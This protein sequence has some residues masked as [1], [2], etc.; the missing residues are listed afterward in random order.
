MQ[1]PG[2]GDVKLG[3]ECRPQIFL[4]RQGTIILEGFLSFRRLNTDPK[5]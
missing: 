4:P 3:E 2:F 1:V 5:N